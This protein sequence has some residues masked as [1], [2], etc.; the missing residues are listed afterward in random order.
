MSKSNNPKYDKDYFLIPKEMVA[1]IQPLQINAWKNNWSPKQQVR[2][3]EDTSDIN[4]MKLLIGEKGI[5]ELIERFLKQGG[6]L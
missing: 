2:F 6:K 3:L 4:R 5:Q 1:K